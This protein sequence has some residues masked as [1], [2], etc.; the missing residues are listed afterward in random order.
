MTSLFQSRRPLTSR[1]VP[2]SPGKTRVVSGTKRPRSPDRGE[3]LVHPVKKRVRPN[4]VADLQKEKKAEREQMEAEF[5]DKYIRA[6]PMWKFYFD[7]EKTLSVSQSSLK[8]RVLQLGAVSQGI[9]N[10]TS[11]ICSWFSAGNCG[12]FR[13]V[14]YARH[15]RCRTSPS[16][17]LG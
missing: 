7:T 8:S 5:R 10:L 2:N 14:C 16:I 12:L 17:Q 6:F 11:A 1:L 4:Q 3:P 13:H 15:K 9:Y